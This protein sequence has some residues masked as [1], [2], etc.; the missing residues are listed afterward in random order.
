M[1]I[2]INGTGN[3]SPQA[4]FLNSSF[5]QDS[6]IA[7]HSNKLTCIEPDYKTLINPSILR[8]MSRMIKMGIASSKI[9]L[10]NAGIEKPGAIITGTGLGCIEDTE[11]FITSIIQNDEQLLTPTPF[12]QSTH[13]TV[14]GQIALLLGCHEYNFTYV[15]R[16]ISFESAL[17]DAIML[18]QENSADN[19]LVGGIDELTETSFK[20]L[21]ELGIYSRSATIN[22]DMTNGTMGG[23]GAA[24]FV[25]SGKRSNR[26]IA[27]ISLVKTFVGETDSSYISEKISNSLK[28]IGKKIEDIDHIITGN[29]GNKKTD[30]IYQDLKEGIF[31]NSSTSTF[32]QYCG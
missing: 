15:H 25:L 23:E 11:K 26:S 5:S 28:E 9:C 13:N 20:I 30:S 6:M 22:P 19:I 27:K 32:K 4:S 31:K 1:L 17:Q 16:G 8:R 3:I 10:E 21:Q 14:G 24:F 2:F 29:S 18:I 12:I 7:Y